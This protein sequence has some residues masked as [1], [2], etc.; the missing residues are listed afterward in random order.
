M[1]SVDSRSSRGQAA[2]GQRRGDPAQRGRRSPGRPARRTAREPAPRR[3][4]RRASGSASRHGSGDAHRLE[5]R[6]A[7][8][9][10]RRRR[11]ARRARC[12]RRAR[13]SAS[14]CS[15]TSR[16]ASS[17]STPASTKRRRASRRSR[18]A[19]RPAR[20]A[21][22]AAAAAGLLSSWA[23]PA[24]IVPSAASRS[25]F[26]SIAG[27]AARSP[28][29]TWRMIRRCT[30]RCASASS[31]E[32]LASGRARRGTSVSAPHAHAAAAPRSAR[33]SRPSRSARPGGRPAPARP[34]VDERGRSAA[35]AA[36]AGARAAARP[37]R[38]CTSPGGDVARLG[39]RDPAR[40]LARRRG[41]RRGRSGAG[42]RAPRSPALM[43]SARYS[44]MSDTAIEPSPTALATRLIERARTSPATKTPGTLVSSSVGVALQRPAGA[45]GVGAGEDEA[46]LVARDD[47]VEPVRPRRGADE[48]EARV[49]VLEPLLAVGPA[50]A[51][52]RAGGRPS[53]SA[54]DR[55][56]CPCARRRS[57]ARR[58]AR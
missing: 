9:P 53:P 3:R 51:S 27:H 5:P 14:R 6:R 57:A 37:A 8:R 49:D 28:G 21:A 2:R 1:R 58:S 54:A 48:D 44:W 30:G 42:R 25:R 34:S 17:R 22:R 24:A 7:A 31:T 19:P 18:R 26:C 15:A 56:A 47:A 41:R 32:A 38:R 36:A 39:G 33:R 4:R 20:A 13:A 23:R 40:E 52:A 16:S 11:R 45:A 12:A 43:P 10:R 55:L 46:A 35:L 29:A 50:D